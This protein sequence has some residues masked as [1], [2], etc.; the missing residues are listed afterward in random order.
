MNMIKILEWLFPILR[1]FL[2]SLS[3][4]LPNIHKILNYI[5]TDFQLSNFTDEIKI[6]SQHEWNAW[7]GTESWLLDRL[8]EEPG[9]YHI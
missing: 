5:F 8:A 3:S 6:L 4:K 2:V 9:K 1:Q 7:S